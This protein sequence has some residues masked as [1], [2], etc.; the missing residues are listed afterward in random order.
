MGPIT[1]ADRQAASRV[2][3]TKRAA[4]SRTDPRVV[5]AHDFLETYGGAERVTQEMALAF[6]SAPVVGIL[7]RPGVAQRMGIAG[8]WRPMLSARPALLRSYRRLTPVFP[9][10]VRAAR[11]P[12]G[13]V[14][15]SSSYAFAHHFR[16]PGDGPQ[17]CYC[18]S[19]LRFAWSMRD[20]Y[21]DRWATGAVTGRAFEAC[22]AWMRRTDRHAASRVTTYCTQSP[23]T[24]EQIEQ[25]YGRRA[26]V[27]GAPVDC[28]LF[29]PAAGNDHDEYVLL[30][31]RLIEPYKKMGIAIDALG[32][33]SR[34]T[35][36]AGDG[37]A[38]P[39]LR[40]RAGPN[41]TFVG[42]VGDEDIVNLMQRAA[43][44]LFPS[45]DDFGLIPV[46]V[47]ACGRPVLA[48]DGGG[49]KFTVV[50][51]VT[52]E[53]FP[54]QTADCIARALERFDPGRYDPAVIRRHAEQWDRHVFRERLREAVLHALP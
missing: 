38:M 41:V 12:A 8:R 9:A 26:E 27:I 6:P 34:R 23:F 53:L 1:P 44:L 25:F 42:H 10:M 20:D 5:I 4:A 45:R 54:E 31:G 49:A 29:R 40:A 2:K 14:L 30:C 52:G 46:E 33:L 28:D 39:E 13:D 18:H 47:M 48:Y 17:V 22:A 3:G 16:L 19:P 11:L 21:R 15:L 24:K 51:G 50:P 36:V 35:V 43:F 37:P 7:G 32:R